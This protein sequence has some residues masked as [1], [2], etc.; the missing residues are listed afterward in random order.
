MNRTVLLEP[1]TKTTQAIDRS[2][3]QSYAASVDYKTLN[4]VRDATEGSVA[5]QVKAVRAVWDPDLSGGRGGY[6][7]PPGTRY[8]GRW[9]DKFGRNCGWGVARRIGNALQAAGRRIGGDEEGGK[10]KAPRTSARAARVERRSRQIQARAGRAEARAERASKRPATPNQ[11]FRADAPVRPLPPRRRRPNAVEREVN[12]VNVA[13]R[14]ANAPEPVEKPKPSAPNRRPRPVRRPNKPVRSE[15][16][17]QAKPLPPRR[18]RPE[19][20]AAAAE[21]I[22][23]QR[24]KPKTP[25]R[26]RTPRETPFDL[27]KLPARDR[28]RVAQA[29][30]IERERLRDKWVR[31]VGQRVADNPFDGD[32]RHQVNQFIATA[33]EQHQPRLR[34]DAEDYFNLHDYTLATAMAKMTPGRR[35][36]ILEQ[37]IPQE[38]VDLGIVRT[39]PKDPEVPV[40][41]AKDLPILHPAGSPKVTTLK[42]E[43]FDTDRRVE[44]DRVQFENLAKIRRG[45][46]ANWNDVD[47]V[48]NMSAEFSKSA[49]EHRV[50]KDNANA[51]L[52]NPR[53]VQENPDLVKDMQAQYLLSK[54]LQQQDEATADQASGRSLILTT[55]QQARLQLNKGANSRVDIDERDKANRMAE[56]LLDHRDR[57]RLN[58]FADA[59]WADFAKEAREK[60]AS[61][62]EK[63]AADREAIEGPRD[64]EGILKAGGPKLRAQQKKIDDVVKAAQGEDGKTQAARLWEKRLR[65]EADELGPEVPGEVDDVEKQRNIRRRWL[66]M[67]IADLSK[68]QRRD[69]D[70]LPIYDH[71][72]QE[73]PDSLGVIFDGG[74]RIIKN[75]NIESAVDAI[76]F[77]KD[78]GSLSD[79]PNRFWGQVLIHNSSF[80]KVDPNTR[81]MEVNK[82]GG[83]IG[84]T[85]IFIAR[86]PDGK[87]G[88]AGYVIKAARDNDNMGEVMSQYLMVQE[89]L[90]VE[91]AGWDGVL[92]EGR[93]AVVLPH[94]GNRLPAGDLKIGHEDRNFVPAAF[95]DQPNFGFER[96]LTH[97]MHNYLMQVDDRHGGNGIVATINGE[98][99]AIP[100][101][102]GWANQANYLDFDEYAR[103]QFSMDN[104]LLNQMKDNVA[105][106][107]IARSIIA[108]YD[109]M[110]ERASR[111]IDGGF[112]EMWQKIQPP[113]SKPGHREHAEQIFATYQRTVRALKDK[114]AFYLSRMLPDQFLGET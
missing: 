61:N 92:E 9:S 113:N 85:R 37:R 31:R 7:C 8:A 39:P 14:R 50:N 13:D 93:D 99:W 68:A 105:S 101:D 81:F 69:A 63:A 45:R 46:S 20:A 74:A 77:V 3:S 40:I 17:R 73:R 29:A 57:N 109:G 75:D 106:E 111:V 15:P 100:I 98:K 54:F 70:M 95:N 44:I 104:R 103:F 32:V 78:G 76:R 110:I 23:I 90:P 33:P 49:A 30:D 36:R 19:R 83:A 72:P 5:L 65:K 84:E 82:N 41:P 1:E 38:D 102:Q 79:V 97:L 12:G 80:D 16:A 48:R 114:R 24:E 86:D 58:N 27:N 53:W 43:D 6:R 107:E 89:G 94:A 59:D 66:K 67:N 22:R 35:K 18:R 51:L 96:R 60:L 25:S 91:G 21:E 52:R 4:H 55:M 88:R 71:V 56:A 112:E 42:L 47:K 108:T 2:S 11:L 10:P 34:R 64:R 28:E 26:L 87:G 62:K